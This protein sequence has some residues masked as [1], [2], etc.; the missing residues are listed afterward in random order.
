MKDSLPFRVLD[1]D[2]PEVLNECSFCGESVMSNQ[3]LLRTWNGE[4]Q[5]YDCAIDSVTEADALEYAKDNDAEAFF[6]LMIECVEG[7][8][9]IDNAL[10]E[11]LPQN[12]GKIAEWKCS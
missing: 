9:S 12:V 4:Y 10:F 6:D 8:H 2:G 11:Y 5:H 1:H 3:P 7:G